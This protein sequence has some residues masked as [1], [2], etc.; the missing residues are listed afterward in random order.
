MKVHRE[1][2]HC[3]FISMF[4][5][6]CKRRQV[7]YVLIGNIFYHYI[8]LKELEPY[9]MSPLVI[10][11]TSSRED[12]DRGLWSICLLL[13]FPIYGDEGGVGDVDHVQMFWIVVYFNNKTQKWCPGR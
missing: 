2:N 11:V 7:F 4:S 1:H 12:A 9:V 6:D 13:A 3:V 5:C 8:P 10:L